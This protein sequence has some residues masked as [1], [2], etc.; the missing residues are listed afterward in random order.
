MRRW[1]AG[2]LGLLLLGCTKGAPAPPDAGPSRPIIACFAAGTSIA[3]PSGEVAIE[4]VRPGD[5]VLAFDVRQQRV[6]PSRVTA[7]Q[8]H[9]GQRT[10]RLSV[11]G[12]RIL[13]VTAEHPVF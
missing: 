7:V 11:A 9:P 2:C 5:A 3:T 6:V 8:S 12:G 10:G 4:L 1:C 13:R